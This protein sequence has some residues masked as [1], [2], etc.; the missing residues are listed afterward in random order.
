M[1]SKNRNLWQDGILLTLT[2]ATNAMAITAAVPFISAMI[3]QLGL[4][5]DRNQTGLFSGLINAS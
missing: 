5:D 2:I 4:V 1:E 3:M